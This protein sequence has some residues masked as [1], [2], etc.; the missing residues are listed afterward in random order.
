MNRRR[1]WC[2]SFQENENV[3]APEWLPH[4]KD[5]DA[6]TGMD[7]GAFERNP[8]NVRRQSG[9]IGYAARLRMVPGVPLIGSP[10]LLPRAANLTGAATHESHT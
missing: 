10:L 6:S 3:F 8:Q 5:G 7:T 1:Q 2:I 4:Q 9:L